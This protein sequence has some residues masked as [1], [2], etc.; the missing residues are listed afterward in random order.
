M[1]TSSALVRRFRIS[2]AMALTII[3]FAVGLYERGMRV[4]RSAA[5]ARDTMPLAAAADGTVLVVRAIDGDTM[6]LEGGTMVRY[7]GIDT[8]ETVDPRKLVEC[9]GPEASRANHALVDGK[10]VRLVADVEDRDKYGRLLR[11]VYLT[12]GTFVNLQLARDGFAAAYTYPPN[13]AHAEEFHA[14]AR[15]AREQRR[16]LWAT[17]TGVRT[18]RG[19]EAYQRHVRAAARARAR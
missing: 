8:P 10:R 9:F 6:E 5:S 1:G 2:F 14:A 16:G 17:C 3:L 11:Y 4:P 19:E 13:V 15:A 18:D 7:L 12:D